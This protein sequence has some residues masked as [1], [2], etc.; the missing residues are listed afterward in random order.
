MSTI[1]LAARPVTVPLVLD[2]HRVALL[3]SGIILLAPSAAQ[4]VNL[5]HQDNLGINLGDLADRTQW[6]RDWAWSPAVGFDP[7]L[8]ADE[9]LGDAWYLGESWRVFAEISRRNPVVRYIG[10]PVVSL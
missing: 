6:M 10:R 5:V 2:A 7:V 1:T 4:N 9:Y 3:K 8:V